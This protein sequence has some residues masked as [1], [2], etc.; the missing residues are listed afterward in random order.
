M[1]MLPTIAAYMVGPQA[2][3]NDQDDVH[4]VTSW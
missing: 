4:M 3:G 1:N 2:I